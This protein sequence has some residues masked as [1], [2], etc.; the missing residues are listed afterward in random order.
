MF[1]ILASIFCFFPFGI[2]GVIHAMIAKHEGE[3]GNFASHR[4]RLYQAKC[5]TSWAIA[6][7]VR[8]QVIC[9]GVIH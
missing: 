8:I 3:K 4:R 7:G 5:W 6:I 9:S 1:S 2:I